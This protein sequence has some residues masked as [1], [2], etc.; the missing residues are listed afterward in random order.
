MLNDFKDVVNSYKLLTEDRPERN[1]LRWWVREYWA[2][3]LYVLGAAADL[4][5][6]PWIELVWAADM[7]SASRP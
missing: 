6:Q 7:M 4:E 1:L 5:L 3:R 2:G